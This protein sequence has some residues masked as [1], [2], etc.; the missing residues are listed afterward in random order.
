MK[1][2]EYT[3]PISEVVVLQLSNEYL[4]RTLAGQSK[5]PVGVETNDDDEDPEVDDMY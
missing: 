5:V 4:E 2:K 3:M 1:R